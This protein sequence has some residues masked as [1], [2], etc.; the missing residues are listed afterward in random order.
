[1]F[2]GGEAFDPIKIDS[3]PLNSTHIILWDSCLCSACV[4]A[5]FHVI[6]YFSFLRRHRF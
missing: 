5:V 1:M 3:G 4:L 2:R 6:D